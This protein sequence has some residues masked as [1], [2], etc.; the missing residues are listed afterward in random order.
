MAEATTRHGFRGYIGSRPY[1]GQRAPQHVQNLVIR[2]YCQ[3]RGMTYLL[4][5]TEWAMPGCTVMLN[6]VLAEL[7]RIEGVVLYSLSMLPEAPAQRL[8]VCQKILAAGA[9]LHGAVE[10]IAITRAADLDSARDLWMIEALVG[11]AADPA[12]FAG[13]K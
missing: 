1:G 3:R 5:A 13:E 6:E 7:D 4:S 10:G 8:A 11:A 12:M 9:S 2:D